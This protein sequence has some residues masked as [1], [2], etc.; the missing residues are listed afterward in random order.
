M[1][2]PRVSPSSL[3]RVP[4]RIQ[5]DKKGRAERLRGLRRWVGSVIIT[6][7]GRPGLIRCPAGRGGRADVSVK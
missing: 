7:G 3:S 6:V 1:R 5:R 2:L 4:V